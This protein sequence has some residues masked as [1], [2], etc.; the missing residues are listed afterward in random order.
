MVRVVGGRPKKK[1]LKPNKKNS[2]GD[3]SND[4]RK[5]NLCERKAILWESGY[6]TSNALAISVGC[7]SILLK[8]VI[9]CLILENYLR[10][11]LEKKH[12]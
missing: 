8:L 9:I 3:K 12:F 7:S 1:L 10:P 4:Q 2:T 5:L 11:Q 6:L